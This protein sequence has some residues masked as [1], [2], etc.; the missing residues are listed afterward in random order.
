MKIRPRRAFWS[1]GPASDT[2]E[3]GFVLAAAAFG[4]LMVILLVTGG[5]F[6]AQQEFQVGT[7]NENAAEAFYLTEE[8]ISE[9]LGARWSFETFGSLALWTPTTLV[10]TIG[11]A[12]LTVEV[13]RTGERTYF[14]DGAA[15]TVNRGL[16]SGATRR[17]GMVMKMFSPDLE[18]PAALTTRGT[19]QLTGTSEIQGGDNYPPDWGSSYCSS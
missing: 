1:P 15:T 12:E 5:F 13:T 9:F 18:P 4:L 14:V 2:R 16:Y 19:T 8:S 11:T 6:I 10:D 3:G 17:V 7:A